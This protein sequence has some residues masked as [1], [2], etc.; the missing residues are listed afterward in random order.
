[1]ITALI[2]LSLDIG[3]LQSAA[4]PPPDV[5]IVILGYGDAEESGR[6]IS[7]LAADGRLRARPAMVPVEGPVHCLGDDPEPTEKRRSCVR[8]AAPA[9]P[10]DAPIVVVALADTMERGSWQRMECI[11]P[12]STGFRRTIYMRDF[13]HPRPDVS[14]SVLSNLAGCIREALE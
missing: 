14:Q 6:I 2:A 1:M 12:G 8:A 7:A 10:R 13:D 5:A 3:G 9:G 11:G 4:P